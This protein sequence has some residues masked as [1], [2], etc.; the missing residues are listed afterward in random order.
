MTKTL[1]SAFKR[2]DRKAILAEVLEMNGQ[3]EQAEEVREASRVTAAL[4]NRVCVEV[5]TV[6]ER[7]PNIL[8]DLEDEIREHIAEGH[9]KKAKKAWKRLSETGSGGSVMKELRKTIKGMK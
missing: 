1:I 8:I 5:E 6:E 3:T 9:K 4:I 7:E 2:N